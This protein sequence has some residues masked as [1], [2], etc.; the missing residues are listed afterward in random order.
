MTVSSEVKNEKKIVSG[1]LAIVVSLA[2]M[3]PVL[4]DAK[5]AC[6]AIGADNTEAQLKMVYGYFNIK[7][8]DVEETVVTNQDERN[9]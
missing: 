8:G 1:I 9:I 2:L 6:V 3:S 7:R 4:A 5:S